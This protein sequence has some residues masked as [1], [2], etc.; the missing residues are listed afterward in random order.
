MN[1]ISPM[2]CEPSKPFDDDN[3][4]F[5][6][7]WDGERAVIFY[8]KGKGIRI[9]SR[10]GD[11]VTFRYPELQ[12]LKFEC[13][14]AV[15]DGEVVVLVDGKSKF[16]LLAQRS[17]LQKKFDIN[18]RMSRIPVTFMAFDCLEIDGQDIT[19][20]PLHERRE[21]L[22]KAVKHNPGLFQWS[23]PL[24]KEG[25]G[26]ALFKMAEE[27]GLEGIVGKHI[28]SPY[29]QGRRCGYWRKCKVEK[30]MELVFDKYRVNPAGV[31]CESRKEGIIV[32]VAGEDSKLV[33]K[34]IDTKGKCVI[35]VKYMEITD[36]GRL[37]M[38]TYKGVRI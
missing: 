28:D 26:K 13:E 15:L 21:Y 14:S 23:L 20:L 38:P 25:K 22:Y 24:D 4:S 12:E 6:I 8:E 2:L 30:S 27:Q 19:Q 5:E 10:R 9:Q 3:Y 35:E 18:L 34:E 7:K 29:L 1:I 17:H 16:S 33:R 31:R 36:R 37:R 11:D 32:Q